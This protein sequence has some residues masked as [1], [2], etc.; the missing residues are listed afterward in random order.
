LKDGSRD[1]TEGEFVNGGDTKTC[2]VGEVLRR[3]GI[4]DRA[5][6]GTANSLSGQKPYK[7]RVLRE[8][9]AIYRSQ[10]RTVCSK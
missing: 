4:A 10:L 1:K 6:P 3:Q 7:T 8:I 2:G 9:G 5:L